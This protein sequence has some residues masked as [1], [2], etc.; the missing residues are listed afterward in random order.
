MRIVP[1]ISAISKCMMLSKVG[2][3]VFHNFTIHRREQVCVQTP[4]SQL[5]PIMISASIPHV[6]FVPLTPPCLGLP[7]YYQGLI[8]SE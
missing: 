6:R 3:W 4:F 1:Q 7:H 2:G 8:L 5:W